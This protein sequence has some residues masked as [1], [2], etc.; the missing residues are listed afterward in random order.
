MSARACLAADGAAPPAR[1]CAQF[2]RRQR[3]SRQPWAARRQ[4]RALL[5]TSS[6]DTSRTRSASHSSSHSCERAY[7]GAGPASAVSQ[8]HGGAQ[9]LPRPRLTPG[10]TPPASLVAQLPHAAIASRQP[11]AAS[12]QPPAARPPCTCMSCRP[13][14]RVD[15]PSRP[16]RRIRWPKPFECTVPAPR[17]GWGDACGGAAVREHAAGGRRRRLR[18]AAAIRTRDTS[19]GSR[20]CCCSALLASH[21]PAARQRSCLGPRFPPC[22]SSSSPP[23]RPCA[24]ASPASPSASQRQPVSASASASPSTHRAGGASWT[25]RWWRP[26]GGA[27]RRGRARAARC[28]RTPPRRAPAPP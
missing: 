7:G 3:P 28:A 22:S 12:R 19:S 14:A 16:L 21:A 20:R 2:C 18:A 23:A 25:R 11:P 13:L 8:P 1:S 17:R 24:A 26:G 5:D 10:S 27:A 4:G 15:P 9:L 6:V